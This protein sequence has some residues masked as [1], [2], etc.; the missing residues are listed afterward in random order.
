MTKVLQ[1]FHRISQLLDAAM[2]SSTLPINRVLV[3]ALICF[4]WTLAKLL[5]WD[6]P[7]DDGK[8]RSV[9]L[10]WCLIRFGIILVYFYICDRT[11]IFEKQLK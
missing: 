5:K 11:N 9:K 4:K 3:A 1:T 6:D 8:R 2:I 7:S 10:L